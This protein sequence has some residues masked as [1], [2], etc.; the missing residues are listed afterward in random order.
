M[1]NLDTYAGFL[2]GPLCTSALVASV[3]PQMRKAWKKLA[4]GLKPLATACTTA[5]S[6]YDLFILGLAGL[7]QAAN[8]MTTNF[9]R[10]NKIL[11]GSI[12]WCLPKNTRIPAG[13]G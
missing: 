11:G 4:G 7:W 6:N 8:K 1:D 5:I 3:H 12:E 10:H 13:G 2:L 9:D